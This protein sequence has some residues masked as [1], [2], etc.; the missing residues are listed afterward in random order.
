MK[1]FQNFADKFSSTSLLI[2]K[3]PLATV[4]MSVQQ[5]T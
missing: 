2:E 1:F 3:S 5:N 4:H